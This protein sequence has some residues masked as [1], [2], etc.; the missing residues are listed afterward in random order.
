M[1]LS[2][3]K[4]N[5]ICALKSRDEKSIASTESLNMKSTKKHN[6]IWKRW[7]SRPL[8]KQCKERAMC[9]RMNKTVIRLLGNVEKKL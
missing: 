1:N 7:I 3:E 4:R 6:W 8:R 9:L 2:T 5:L